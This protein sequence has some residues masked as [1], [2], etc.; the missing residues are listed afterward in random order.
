ME[1]QTR[2]WRASRR[3]SD[4]SKEKTPVAETE[5]ETGNLYLHLGLPAVPLVSFTNFTFT[6]TAM[7]TRFASRP[8]HD[9]PRF[10]FFFF[11]L[12]FA[13]SVRSGL[14]ARSRKYKSSCEDRKRRSERFSPTQ[15]NRPRVCL[16]SRNGPTF[17]IPLHPLGKMIAYNSLL[18]I[19][20]NH[21]LSQLD[22]LNETAITFVAVFT[23]ARNRYAYR[24]F[25]VEGIANFIQSKRRGERIRDIESKCELR[26][27]H[28]ST[29]CINSTECLCTKIF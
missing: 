16:R 6:A 23:W 7:A 13:S 22:R 28:F 29:E 9:R 18:I 2:Q 5:T 8:L 24:G 19:P 27:S 21:W 15:L 20:M 12:R 10:F 14:D 25:I 11:S 4:R 1:S 17:E 26:K 3:D